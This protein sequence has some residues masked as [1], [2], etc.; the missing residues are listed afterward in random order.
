MSFPLLIATAWERSLD[1][2]LTNANKLKEQMTDTITTPRTEQRWRASSAGWQSV[3]CGW[4]PQQQNFFF[5]E[6]G[7]VYS[8]VWCWSGTAPWPYLILKPSAQTWGEQSDPKIRPAQ[9]R[10]LPEL[11][12]IRPLLRNLL[13]GS[14]GF[15]PGPWKE[16]A[17]HENGKFW[18]VVF[19]Q[20]VGQGQLKT[21]T[22]LQPNL[23]S[24]AELKT[25]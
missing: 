10:N 6:L 12:V 23:C 22:N 1:L 16:F 17:E 15:R 21:M 3:M 5:P 8:M 13:W 4:V 2:K 11:R 19:F 25:S 24:L 20:I 18:R 14:P 9:G 7:S